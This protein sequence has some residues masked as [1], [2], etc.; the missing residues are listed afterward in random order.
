MAPFGPNGE[1]GLAEVRTPHIGG[2]VGFYRMGGDPLNLVAQ[3]DGVTSHPVFS[4]DLDMGLAGDLDG[5]GQPELVVFAQPFREVV[6]LRRTEE[7]LLGGRPLAV[8][9]WTT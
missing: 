7:R 4:R 5:D 2:I 6:A 9:Q 3:L 1:L 8:K